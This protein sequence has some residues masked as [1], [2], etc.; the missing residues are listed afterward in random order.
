TELLDLLAPVTPRDADIPFWS[1]VD[2]RWLDT[3]TMDAAY[4]YR[5]L[6]QT[7]RLADATRQLAEQ[8]HDLFIEVSPHPVL[9]GAIQDTLHHTTA[10]TLGTL[11]RDHG[12]TRR[13]LTSLAEAHVHGAPADFTPL[14]TTGH[15]TDLP[16]YPFQRN[17]YWLEAAPGA[18]DVT[19]VGLAAADHPMLGAAVP[20]ADGH[21]HLLTGLI[22][23][24]THPWLADHTVMGT[25]LLPGTAMVDLAVRAGDEVG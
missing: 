14:L 21:G 9:T 7:V 23:R 5:N 16:T 3:T 6:R 19:A 18:S 20:L 1:T 12:G 17:R 2:S 8:G 15:R 24:T 4:W 13:F 25:T 10:H 11:R 22:S